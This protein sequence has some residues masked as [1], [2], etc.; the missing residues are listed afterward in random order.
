MSELA[1][2][3]IQCCI[4]SP[5]YWGLRKYS[6]NQDLIWGGEKDCQHEWG[7]KIEI[8]DNRFRGVNAMVAAQHNAAVWG[9][10]KMLSSFCSLCGAWKGALGLEPTPELYLDHLVGICREIKRVLRKDGVFFLNIGDTYSA[11]RWSDA[12]GTG[13]WSSDK[14]KEAN[15]V[16]NRD[17]AGLPTKNLCLIPFRLAIRLQEDGWW[18]RSV[19]IW[20]KNNP[21][22]ESVRDRP[23]ES[24]E[25]ILMLTKSAR[26]YWNQEAVREPLQPITIK[27]YQYDSGFHQKGGRGEL[28][29][30]PQKRGFKSKHGTT[31]GEQEQ[32]HGQ[33]I[34]NYPF[35]RNL[36]SVWEFSTQG[37]AG[38]HFAT[39]PEKLPEI[40]IKAATPEVGCCAECGK[41]W[42]RVTN[43]SYKVRALRAQTEKQFESVGGSRPNM[44]FMG[45]KI[46][47]TLGWK[48]QCKCE[49]DKTPSLVLD[50]F[51]G[52]GTTLLVASKLGRRSVGYELAEEYCRLAVERNKQ[53][54]LV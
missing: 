18:V 13:A 33:D 16:I 39:Y 53:A 10:G 51:A 30:F 14:K 44:P 28:Y 5:P 48:P 20:S 45:D 27:R 35:G 54:V 38:A 11:T 42:V 21:M 1:D 2:N 19:I 36:R 6:G 50:P 24:H 37:F 47:I 40:C 12:K 8:G 7:K 32:F 9:G 17:G 49:A 43:H 22:P 23:T 15:P 3:S 29:G 34:N 31:F 52:S 26:Y 46:S 4:T 25:Y 41:P